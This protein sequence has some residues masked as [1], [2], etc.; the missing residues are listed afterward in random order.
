MEIYLMNLLHPDRVMFCLSLGPIFPGFSDRTGFCQG[1][2]YFFELFGAFLCRRYRQY[3]PPTN[4]M[5]FICRK[6]WLAKQIH[7][8]YAEWKILQH[9]H[10]GKIGFLFFVNSVKGSEYATVF[11]CVEW[12]KTSD[13]KT[14]K[15]DRSSHPRKRTGEEARPLQ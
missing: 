4:K 9:S 13:Q 7:V 12:Y 10:A 1:V 6:E 8:D 2:F 3:F 11:N 15:R 5:Y 14:A